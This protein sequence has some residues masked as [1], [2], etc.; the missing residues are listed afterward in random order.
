MARAA[1]RG[2]LL[3]PL[4]ILT[5]LSACSSEPRR[6]LRS[7]VAEGEYA[8]A[9]AGVASTMQTRRADRDYLLDRMR[10]G[11]LLLADG[12]PDAAE[13]PLLEVFD[14]LRTQGINDDKTVAAAILGEEGVL[15][16]KGEPF[17][18]ALAFVSIA[19]QRAWRGEWDNA[20][21]AASSSLFLLKDFGANERGERLST[22]DIAREAARS[23]SGPDSQDYLDKGYTPAKTNFAL[24]YLMNAVS[25]LALAPGDPARED[26]ARDNFREAFTLEPGLRPLADAL[27]TRRANTLVMVN[28]GLGP[29]KVRYGPDNALARFEPAVPSDARPLVVRVNGGPPTTFATACD[30]NRMATDHS[31]N[32]FEDV[33]RA[34]SAIGQAMIAAGAITAAASRND[35][36][37]WIGLGLIL[38]GLFSSATAQAD[39]R[40]LEVVPQRVYLAALDLPSN[41]VHGATIELQVA[42]DPLSRLVLPGVTGPE[43]GEPLKFHYARLP[44]LRSPPPPLWANTGTVLY[45]NDSYQSPVAGEDLPYIL[46]GRCVRRPSNTILARYQQ[47]GFLTDMTLSDLENLYR[48][49]GIELGDHPPADPRAAHILEGGHRLDAPEAGSAGFA[50]LFCAEHPKYRPRNREVAA[51]AERIER[52]LTRR[53]SAA[54]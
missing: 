21:A 44:L 52:E 47:A 3:V 7:L 20:R 8:R 17:E 46:G 6:R 33:R 32:N 50:R 14:T 48:L 19:A 25:N 28:Y 42:G 26:E 37:R 23:D 16:W 13:A 34:K 54:P 15:F 18:Q 10:L 49:E 22:L 31:W 4:L 11:L 24:G 1:R 39:T 43:P 9:A 30:V 35:T 36:G 41:P 29:R 40:Y 5:A 2:A 53:A 45:A 38:G 12:R 27:I 51:L